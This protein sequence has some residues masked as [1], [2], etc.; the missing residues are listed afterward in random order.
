M[1]IKQY[2][3]VKLN[4]FGMLSNPNAHAFDRR[5]FQFI[6]LGVIPNMPGH[7]VVIGY[8]TGKAYCGFHP[9]NFIEA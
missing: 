5:D 6:F 1:T 2:S 9:E 7:C 3:I 8:I 4:D